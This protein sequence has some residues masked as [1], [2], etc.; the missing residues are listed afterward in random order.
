MAIIVNKK[1]N[2]PLTLA[3]NASNDVICNQLKKLT[4]DI[5]IL[6]EEGKDIPYSERKKWNTF[7]LIDPLDGTKEFIK[8][9][10]EFSVNIA[11]SCF[12]MG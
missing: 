10:G 12:Y 9:N 3:D 2:S 6:S 1:D 4:P 7:W 8:K 11:L 5:P